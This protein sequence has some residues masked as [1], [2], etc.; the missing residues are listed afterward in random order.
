MTKTISHACISHSVTIP[1]DIFENLKEF[2]RSSDYE[3]FVDLPAS[4][5]ISL[6]LG[7]ALSEN[8][9]THEDLLKLYAQ[10]SNVYG[11]VP[12]RPQGTNLEKDLFKK[13]VNKKSPFIKD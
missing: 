2:K 11:R 9:V 5:V 4:T 10:R 12:A 8:R 6:I 7:W 13:I 1:N 3:F